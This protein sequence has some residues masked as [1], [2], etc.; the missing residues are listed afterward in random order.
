MSG[1][2]NVSQRSVGGGRERE[3]TGGLIDIED[4]E[5]VV[6]RLVDDVAAARGVVEGGE[7]CLLVRC[8]R[9][10]YFGGVDTK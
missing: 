4:V 10:D 6:G 2:G 1:G 8:G 9:L 7:V 3:L 5:I